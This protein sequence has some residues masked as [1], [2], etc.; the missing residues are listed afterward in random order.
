MAS[1]LRNYLRVFRKGMGLYQ[2]EIA[3]LVGSEKGTTVSRY[4]HN[5]R[6]PGLKI[7]LAYE[8]ILRVPARSLF[9]GLAQEVE[10]EIK[11]RARFLVQKL[12]KQKQD[13]L[14]ERKLK[15]LKM[16]ASGPGTKPGENN[17]KHF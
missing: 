3:F 4:E 8:F 14:T 11:H 13:R 15:M 9:A 5:E 1:K 17:E 6:I 16:L 10:E 12:S 2:D 7:I